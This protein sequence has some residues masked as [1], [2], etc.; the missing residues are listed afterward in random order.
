MPSRPGPTE[1]QQPDCNKAAT[2]QGPTEI[3]I[4][5]EFWHERWQ[6]GE[7]GWH[8]PEINLHLQEHWP[9]IGV[10]GRVLVPL[11]GKTL[12][13][14]WLAGQGLRVLGVEIS[15]IAVEALFRD[16]GLTPVVTDEPPFQRYRLD[17]IEV[18]CGDFFALNPG[19]V[20]EVAAVYDRASL[21]ALPPD[22]RRRYVEHL[23]GL[24]NPTT[25]VL[26][27]TLDY[28]Q[29]EMAGPPFSVQDSEVIALFGTRFEV[30]RLADLDVLGETP[31]LRS[32]GVTSLRERVYALNPLA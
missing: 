5:P 32:R 10:T 8:L 17:E 23:T 19:H 3:H 21:I 15:P 28:D 4:Q 16:N 26:L 13:L 14:L 27:I 31:S 7:T 25:R 9:R 29:V 2:A 30:R 20:G 22:W 1:H 24:L 12:D 11:C 18:L 6:R